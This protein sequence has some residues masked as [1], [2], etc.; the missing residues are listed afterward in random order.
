MA[1]TVTDYL[2]ER[3]PMINTDIN[4]KFMEAPTPWITLYKQETWEDGKSSKQRTFQFDRAM[5]KDDADPVEW[6][7]MST[8]AT[9]ANNYHS[10]AADATGGV[11]PADDIVFSETVREYNLQHKA[12]WGPPM[13]TNMLR[14]KFE[15]TKQMG[16]CVKALHDQSREYW[17]DRKRDEYVRIADNLVVLDSGFDLGGGDYNSIIF[18]THTGT[19]GSILTNGFTDE[20]YEFLN[21]QGAGMEALGNANGRPVY[22]LVTSPRQSRRLIMSD[23]D[24]REDFRYSS[25]N[26]KLLAAMGIKWTYNGFTHLIDETVNRWEWVASGGTPTFAISAS[27]GLTATGTI[28]AGLVPTVDGSLGTTLP[29]FAGSVIYIDSKKYLVVSRTANPL[30][31]NLR[32]IDGGGNAAN[33]SATSTFS[34]WMKVPRFIVSGGKRTPYSRWLTATWEDSTIF[35]QGVCTSL[36][37]KPITSVGQASFDA[38]NYTGTYSWKNYESKADNP[39]GTIGQFRGV[40]ANG[41]RPDNVEF[42]IVIRHLAVPRPDGRIMDGSSL[43]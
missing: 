6:T 28:S 39:D 10:Q 22:G 21:H 1:I 42:G 37:P 25:Q 4:Q 15:M 35:H 34:A 23:P 32:R 7:N 33:V 5:I 13:N 24:I 36:V 2:V 27:S 9:E 16:A 11:P 26:E 30:V 18:P 19:D 20:I 3:A 31:V 43:G 40:L 41:T 17:V 12:V 38:V 29:L 8:D 14:D